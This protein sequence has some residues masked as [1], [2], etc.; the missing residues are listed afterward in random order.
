MTN[1]HSGTGQMAVYCQILPLGV[2]SSCRAL[3]VPVGTLFTKFVLFLNMPLIPISNTQQDANSKG[4]KT[5]L[6]FKIQIP[7]FQKKNW[8]VE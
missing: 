3:S 8:T 1:V 6:N 5:D 4:S 7:F 2:L